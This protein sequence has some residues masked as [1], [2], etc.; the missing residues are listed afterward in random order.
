MKHEKKQINEEVNAPLGIV[1]DVMTIRIK[2]GT[3]FLERN[4]FI[5]ALTYEP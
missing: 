4:N 3:P 1:N 5:M 2:Q